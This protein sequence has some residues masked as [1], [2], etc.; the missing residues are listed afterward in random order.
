MVYLRPIQG[1]ELVHVIDGGWKIEEEGGV[2]PAER[3][4]PVG[5]GAGSSL[6]LVLGRAAGTPSPHMVR[7]ST[8]SRRS[9]A[10]WQ[11]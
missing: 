9:A 4:Y 7:R 11:S 10:M 6:Q 3:G 8:S 5:A 1:L 2:A